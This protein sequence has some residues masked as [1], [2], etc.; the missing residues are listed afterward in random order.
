MGHAIEMS[1]D[2]GSALR[3]DLEL[4]GG[5]RDTAEAGLADVGRAGS[6]TAREPARE[7]TLE[8]VGGRV[9]VGEKVP[10]RSDYAPFEV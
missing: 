2:G 8:G 4:Y 7:E 1:F 9:L 10:K 3:K 5:A 6:R